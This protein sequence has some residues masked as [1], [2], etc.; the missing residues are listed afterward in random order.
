MRFMTLRTSRSA[1]FLVLALALSLAAVPGSALAQEAS[2]PACTDMI[3]N[4]G[5]L[6][7]DCED[8]TCFGVGV[9][10]EGS[11]LLCMDGMDNDGDGL[12]DCADP[13]C[14][15]IVM[16]M[17]AGH[18]ADG[19]DQDLDGRTDCCDGPLGEEDCPCAA[20]ETG[21]QCI[22]GVDN[23]GDGLIDCEESAS[24]AGWLDCQENGPGNCSDGIDNDLDGLVDCA[25]FD[26]VSPG[27][28]PE[29]PHCTDAIDN[30]LDGLTDCADPDC[31][32][33][34]GGRC[35]EQDFCMDGIDNDLDSFVDC[36]DSEC[37]VLP[38][39]REGYVD[40]FGPTNNCTDGIDNDGDTDIDCNPSDDF[41]CPC[42]VENVIE[43]TCSDGIDNDLDGQ[44]DCQ[45]A[46]DGGCACAP[47]G[48]TF[49]NCHDGVDN[50]DDGQ[51]DC[52]DPDCTATMDCSEGAPG[53]C[54]DGI[55]NDQDYLL[56]CADNDCIG[57][58]ACAEAS[59]FLCLNGM[60]DD[61]DTLTDCEDPECVVAGQCIEALVCGNGMDDDADGL[62]DCDDP[63]CFGGSCAE[64]GRCEDGL[65]NDND[66]DVDCQ[67]IDCAGD[68]TGGDP[69]F[70]GLPDGVDNCDFDWNPDQRDAD[71][72]GDGDACDSDDD[73]DTIP[74]GPDN[75]ETVPNP[76]QEDADGDTIGDACEGREMLYWVGQNGEIARSFVET[77]EIEVLVPGPQ[78]PSLPY[79][80]IAIHPT[81]D[82]IYWAANEQVLRSDLDG[83]NVQVVASGLDDPRGVAYD[84]ATDRIYWTDEGR[85]V[86]QRVHPDGGLVETLVSGLPSGFNALPGIAVGGGYVYWTNNSANSI[87]RLQLD[88]LGL[89]PETLPIGGLG[90]PEGIAVDV[91]R[92]KLYWADSGGADLIG[93]SDLDG[94]NQAIFYDRPNVDDPT[95]LAVDPDGAW[96]YWTERN[97]N[98][99]R[100]LRMRPPGVGGPPCPEVI[101]VDQDGLEYI[102]RDRDSGN[103]YW[104]HGF[105]QGLRKCTGLCATPADISDVHDFSEPPAGIAV[106]ILNA[107]L[108][109]F[110]PNRGVIERGNLQAE[111][112][113][114]ILGQAHGI[115]DVAVD[116]VNGKL[117]WAQPNGIGWA[118]LDGSMASILIGTADGPRELELDL[119]AG[120]VVWTDSF[121]RLGTADLDGTVVQHVGF[122]DVQP[123][124]LDLDPVGGWLYY[125]D[126]QNVDGFL[127]A[128][129]GG[130]PRV[131]VSDAYG[132]TT[133]QAVDPANG[134]LFYN[135]AGG[136]TQ[137][138]V[139][140]LNGTGERELLDMASVPRDLVYVC[141]DEDGDGD[142]VGDWCDNCPLEVNTRSGQRRRGRVRQRLR[143]LSDGHERGSDGR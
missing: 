94:S 5:D 25:D 9:C 106:D 64:A 3:D 100:V 140:N 56:D 130:T 128:G 93:M 73:G 77:G 102:A 109:A 99:R 47:E 72:D 141:D 62:V 114:P 39:C 74:D 87:Q 26:C 63:D 15:V 43:G 131:L 120:K 113:T 7:I 101:A 55:D 69:D 4:D 12:I 104:T 133:A 16:C 85:G 33:V 83:S 38:T 20:D 98:S 81:L 70:D 124:E 41:N 79:F 44:V 54:N 17:E 129:L 115:S 142:T 123:I 110:Y 68:C 88:P 137:V 119:Q 6:L 42:G 50:D 14:L 19:L 65:D 49:A 21:A 58:P 13:N 27:C 60:D 46:G 84:A 78:D 134:R 18:C 52:L 8:P 103:L 86:I 97:F 36:E 40:P 82:R 11:P 112:L 89:P 96:V 22:D 23:D 59:M 45:G 30:D 107:A 127:R 91:L 1:W 61:G 135:W 53:N 57:D 132:A 75:C 24:C 10:E 37:R 31:Q 2:P 34:G 95:G 35:V 116:P 80:G 76:M 105:Q 51:V 48:A 125:G 138:M 28:N 126:I 90:T 143:Q 139:S 32:G 29:R 108:Y 92:N 118:N 71:I 67:D 122:G 111:G 121:K 117:Y 136:F 66:G